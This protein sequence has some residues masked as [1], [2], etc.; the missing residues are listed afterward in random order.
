MKE[1]ELDELLTAIRAVAQGEAVIDPSIAG[2]VL[3]EL[4]RP[5]EQEVTDEP[6]DLAERDLEILQLVAQGLSNQEIADQL[7]LAEK[8]IRNRL[9]LIANYYPFSC[10]WPCCSWQRLAHP[11]KR[12]KQKKP[13][14]R[15]AKITPM[16]RLT[17]MMTNTMMTTWKWRETAAPNSAVVKTGTLLSLT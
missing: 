13:Y 14:L 11:H 9:S 8:T 15:K 17:I 16:K 2:R 3:A 6:A 5:R 10:C 1:V 12:P 4:R 7:F